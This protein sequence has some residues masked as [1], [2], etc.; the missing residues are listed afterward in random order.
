MIL[1]MVDVRVL[2]SLQPFL[3]RLKLNKKSLFLRKPTM[4]MQKCR[5]YAGC[6]FPGLKMNVFDHFGQFWVLIKG[7]PPTYWST[8]SPDL[9]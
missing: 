8:F 2:F 4:Q 1:T 3:Q 5:V 7:I 9:Y 6:E